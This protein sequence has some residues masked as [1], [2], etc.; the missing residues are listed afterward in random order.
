MALAD[1]LYEK[2]TDEEDARLCD[3]IGEAAC[4]E[5][6]LNCLCISA[7]QLRRS[8]RRAGPHGPGGR[9]YGI[10]PA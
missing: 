3:E 6:P 4:R 10:D 9:L 5:T 2:L 7:G 1:D 8:G